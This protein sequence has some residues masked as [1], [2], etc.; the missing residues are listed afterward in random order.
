[1]LKLCFAGIFLSADTMTNSNLN[2]NMK[3]VLLSLAMAMALMTPS[4]LQAKVKHLLPKPQHITAT[5]NAAAL[6]L[7]GTVTISYS[8]GAEKCDLRE[9]R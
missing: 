4:A 2:K 1:M 8:G 7:G 3:K 6:T 9:C 5:E